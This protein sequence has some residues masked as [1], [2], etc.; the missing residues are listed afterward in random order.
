MDSRDIFI[1]V[2]Q[3][4]AAF[5]LLNSRSST[6]SCH[7][8]GKLLLVKMMVRSEKREYIEQSVGFMVSWNQYEYKN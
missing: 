7:E 8:K 3:D 4:D 5:T 6:H 2:E 1:K